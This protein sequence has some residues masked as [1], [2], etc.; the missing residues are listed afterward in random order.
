M[1]LMANP[2]EY[3]KDSGLSEVIKACGLSIYCTLPILRES[4]PE[5]I[6]L[7]MLKDAQQRQLWIER[8]GD[9]KFARVLEL[10]IYFGGSIPWLYEVCRADF[11][12][13]LDNSKDK[14]N[15]RKKLD[16]S[17]IENSYALYFD[18]DQ[19]DRKALNKIVNRHFGGELDLVVDDASH[20]LHLTRKSFEILFPKLRAG[21]H[22]VIEDYGWAHLPAAD[23]RREGKFPSMIQIALELTMLLA[24]NDGWIKDI[25]IDSNTITIERGDAPLPKPFR[26]KTVVSNWAGLDMKDLRALGVFKPSVQQD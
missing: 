18:T 7:V 11:I 23:R 3:R 22:Y 19:S 8:V 9:K 21:G 10:G 6:D 20:L 12:V 15:I 13:G 26:I 25:K 24:T 17:T 16:K 14:P 5:K 1:T 4:P 2:T